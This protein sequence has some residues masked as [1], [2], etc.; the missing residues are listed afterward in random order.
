[1]IKKNKPQDIITFITGIFYKSDNDVTT[2]YFIKINSEEYER[3]INLGIYI[4]DTQYPLPY[5]VQDIWE[6]ENGTEIHVFPSNINLICSLELWGKY[7]FHTFTAETQQFYYDEEKYY[8]DK[9]K[10]DSIQSVADV[11]NYAIEYGLN[12]AN[13]KPY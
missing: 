1:M 13:I 4:I 7:F 8:N 3:N 12:K 11:I 10:T 9:W 2:C 5:E 6:L